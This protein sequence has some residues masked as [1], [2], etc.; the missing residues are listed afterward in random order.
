MLTKRLPLTSAAIAATFCLAIVPAE[1]ATFRVNPYLQQPTAEG[2]L[3]TWFTEADQAGTLTVTGPA[4]ANPLTFESAP[5]FQPL[6]SY[7]T[8]EKINRL[9]GWHLA[10]G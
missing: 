3:V 2:M 9:T 8:A 1:A 7:T 6:L 4:L 5:V 10:H